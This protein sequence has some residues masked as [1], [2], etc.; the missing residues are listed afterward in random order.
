MPWGKSKSYNF[1][2][3]DNKQINLSSNDILQKKDRT[4]Q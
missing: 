1:K 4:I 3:S 2:E